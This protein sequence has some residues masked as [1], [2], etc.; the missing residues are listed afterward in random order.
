MQ[1][2]A[3]PCQNK[4]RGF[5][6]DSVWVVSSYAST[7]FDYSFHIVFKVHDRTDSGFLLEVVHALPWLNLEATI[8]AAVT[9]DGMAASPYFMKATNHCR[10]K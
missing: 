3:L 10:H 7:E 2:T 6:S 4:V 9:D 8:K 1:K 5:P